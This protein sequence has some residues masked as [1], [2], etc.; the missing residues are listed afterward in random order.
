M[1]VGGHTEGETGTSRWWKEEP[2]GWW[3]EELLGGGRRSFQRA[4]LGWMEEIRGCW[5]TRGVGSEGWC[6]EQLKKV[7]ERKSKEGYSRMWIRI[8]YDFELRSS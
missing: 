8:F 3:R 5:E 1:S 7:R 2:L 6:K 4:E